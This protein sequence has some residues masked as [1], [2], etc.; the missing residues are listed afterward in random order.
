[1]VKKCFRFF[2]GFLSFLFVQIFRWPFYQSKYLKGKCFNGICAIGWRVAAN[3]LLHRIFFLKHLG[4]PWPVSPYIDCSKNIE[5]D[6]DDVNNF[7]GSGNYYQTF[8]AKIV[9]GKGCWI[10]K[11]VGIITSNHDLY[12]PSEHQPG[13]DVVLGE[14]CWVGMNSVI[15]PGVTLGPHTVVG[16]G[17]VVT[18]SFPEG[19]VII[20]G[21]PAKVIRNI[22]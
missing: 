11:N 10:A 15:L 9:I 18:K 16:A 20:G 12:N 22:Q 6:I 13:E 7:W 3:D 17:S 8:D 4:I 2:H 1:M 5:F 21:N 14:H 19:Y